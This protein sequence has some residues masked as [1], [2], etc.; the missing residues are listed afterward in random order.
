MNKID[1][2]NLNTGDIVRGKHS[3][4]SFVVMENDTERGIVTVVRIETMA[5]PEEWDL[6]FKANLT[7]ISE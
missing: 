7:R 4:K 2:E 5:N 6:I 1:F 3:S